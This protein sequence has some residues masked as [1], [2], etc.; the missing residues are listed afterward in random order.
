MSLFGTPEE[1][2]GRIGWWIRPLFVSAL[3]LA[4]LFALPYFSPASGLSLKQKLAQKQA[5]LNAAYAEYREFQDK[6][7]VLAEKQNAAEIRLA[8]ID[9]AINDIENEINLAKKDMAIAQAQ[10][11]ERVVEIYKNGYSSS[12]SVYLEVLLG[13]GDFS[14]ILERFSLLRDMADQDDQLFEQV[15][16]YLEDSEGDEAALAEKREAQTAQMNELQALQDEVGAQFKASQGEYQRLVN[17]VLNLREQVRQAEEAARRA[18]EEAARRAAAARQ[19]RE[20][21]SSSSSSSSSGS[22]GSSNSSG[23]TVQGGTFVFP[24]AG[25]H[26]YV[27]S[28]GAARSGGRSHKGTDILASRGTPVVACVS[29]TISR[30]TP[31][32]SGLGGITIWLRG[33]NGYSY[34]YAH[35][36]GI[37]SGIRAGVS[38]GAG[39]TIGWVGSTGNAGSCNH[40]HFCAYTSSGTAV[41]PYATLRAND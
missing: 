11:A 21:A 36:D 22:S 10:L 13:D 34:Y 19:Q 4:F 29:G 23:G 8:D 1:R 24:V 27:D 39:E 38:V 41:N 15:T 17:Q 33:N 25:P 30:T 9:D 28:W 32:D 18:A 3:L 7:D 16:A 31:T 5:E 40:L 2:T 35:L 14:T 37:A 26:S 12:T 20:V 6:L